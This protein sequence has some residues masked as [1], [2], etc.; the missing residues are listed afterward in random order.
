MF[1]RSPINH[2]QE[3]MVKSGTVS[4]HTP[5]QVT[6]WAAG[7][8]FVRYDA[9]RQAFNLQSR[10]ICRPRAAVLPAHQTVFFSP[11]RI[12]RPYTIPGNCSAQ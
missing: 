7:F 8:G 5:K 4:G 2:H 11:P 9:C 12:D 1:E 10:I 6:D 3:L